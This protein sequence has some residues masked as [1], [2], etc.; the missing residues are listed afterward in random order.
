MTFPYVVSGTITDSNSVNPSGIPVVIRNDR[1]IA[2]IKV[3]TDA[4]GGYVGDLANLAGGWNVGDQITVIAR[5]GLEDGSDSFIIASDEASQSVDITTS[6]ILDSADVSYCTISEVYDE[7]DGK[8]TDDISAE[9]VRNNVLRAEAFIDLKTKT[10]FK[11]NTVID[12]FYDANDENMWVS[13]ER[14]MGLGAST[15]GLARADT[16][17]SGNLDSIHLRNK[18]ILTVTSFSRNVA[19]A[20]EADSFGT[21]TEQTG[22]GGD[23]IVE[24]DKGIL[25]FVNNKPYFGKK[26][27][28][29]ITYTWGL[30]RS[31]TDNE[32]VR[33]R[34]LVREL[35][36]LLTV[37]QILTSKGSSSQF[38]S[39]DSI[40]LEGIAIT[41]NISQ[42]TTYLQ[43]QK[44]RIDELFG[45]LGVF[46]VGMGLE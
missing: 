5:Y 30:D 24:K 1:T 34:E 31:A 8:N 14:R 27:S 13:P 6:E 45:E 43:W 25:V 16:A 38:S 7:L 39:Q 18:P 42:T 9:R 35:C 3:T 19:G 17:L 44:D 15:L 36:I 40:S 46:N 23:F 22:S 29:K 28:F 4:N 10:S 37:R 2:S 21:L 41:K 11:S 33:K 26:R 32:S 12:E 20:S